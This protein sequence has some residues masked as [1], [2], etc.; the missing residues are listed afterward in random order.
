[1][2]DGKKGICKLNLVIYLFISTSLYFEKTQTCVL[3]NTQVSQLLHMGKSSV[4]AQVHSRQKKHTLLVCR[5][6]FLPN[7]V[8][9]FF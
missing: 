4:N 1:M 9:Y 7:N 3:A 8:Q 6:L 5:G 2:K